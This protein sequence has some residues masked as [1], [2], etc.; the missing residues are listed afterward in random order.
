VFCHVLHYTGCRIS[1]ALA[2]TP[3]RQILI[4]NK[5]IVFRTLKKRKQDRH[6]NPKD[7]EYRRVEVPEQLIENLDLA[8]DL[9][10]FQNSDAL[11][12]VTKPNNRMAINQTC[13]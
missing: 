6:G 1:E 13:A 11:C 2:L 7:P 4:E 9:K 5:V 10:R 12:M 3:S 8:F